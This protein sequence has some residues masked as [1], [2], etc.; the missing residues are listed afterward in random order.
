M[1]TYRVNTSIH[2]ELSGEGFEKQAEKMEAIEGVKRR[3]EF[4][5]PRE[6]KPRVEQAAADTATPVEVA[7]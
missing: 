1:L 5:N 2:L 6:K 4:D 3:L 7:D